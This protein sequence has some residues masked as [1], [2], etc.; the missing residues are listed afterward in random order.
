MALGVGEGVP[1]LS[2]KA[3][4]AVHLMTKGLVRRILEQP[5]EKIRELSANGLTE[6]DLEMIAE[7]FGAE[8]ATRRDDV[9][10]AEGGKDV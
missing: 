7:V 9:E 5:L 3:D 8:A 4:K 1:G 10:E 2:G 6:R